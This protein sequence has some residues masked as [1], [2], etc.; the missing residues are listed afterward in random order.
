MTLLQQLVR[1]CNNLL[2]VNIV[3]SNTVMPKKKTST[4][5]RE[6]IELLME[7]RVHHQ[8][9][10][11]DGWLATTERCL[12]LAKARIHADL[13]GSICHED[14]LRATLTEEEQRILL[15]DK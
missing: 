3:A 8:Y 10:L 6:V 2:H 13:P 11:A 7:S 4:A 5:E 12:E 14:L 9:P 15:D 1:H